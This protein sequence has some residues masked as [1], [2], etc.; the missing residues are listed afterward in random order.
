[1]VRKIKQKQTVK[2]NVKQT[3]KVVIGKL[4]KPKR[5]TRRAIK[6]SAPDALAFRPMYNIINQPAPVS[7]LAQEDIKKDYTG[8]LQGLL[9][10]VRKYDIVDKDL[11]SKPNE[12]IE[13]KVIEME[14][15]TTPMKPNYA[16]S[17]DI[18]NAKNQIETPSESFSPFVKKE[19][20]A[21]VKRQG[22]D[23]IVSPKTGVSIKR[24]GPAYKKLIKEG[25]KLD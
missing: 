22:E 5:R 17:K 10:F 13:G 25:Y 20:K 14:G 3:V 1:M 11:N 12:D 4:D 24:G 2:Q 9:A 15:M 21:P 23:F 16:F 7:S 6:S 8:S 18:F 19:K